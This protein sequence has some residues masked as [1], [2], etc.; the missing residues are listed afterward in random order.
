MNIVE[1][2]KKFNLPLGEYVIVG[3]GT[4]EALKIRSANDVDMAV[5]PRLFEILLATGEW[6]KEERYGKIFLTRSGVD[7][8]PSLDWSEYPTTTKEA[9]ESALIIDGVP[10]M[11]LEELKKFKLALGRDKDKADIILIENYQRKN[12][13]TF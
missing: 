11:N 8:I 12:H 2:V 13:G 4:L 1:R 10:F 5:T 3:S 6:E 7:V 9:I